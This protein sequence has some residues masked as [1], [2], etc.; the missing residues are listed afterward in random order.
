[1]S[2]R[3]LEIWQLAKQ[4]VTDIYKMTEMLP[5]SELYGITQQIRRSANS[6]L[7]NIVEGYGRRKY[8]ADYDKF[9]V[10]ALSSNHETTSHLEV[11]F[12]TGML[13]DK[14]LYHRLHKNSVRL[15]VKIN[16]FHQVLVRDIQ[17]QIRR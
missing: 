7:S 9:I 5:K 6:V 13:T 8:A 12:D 4:Q 3:N 16:N 17:S 14:E 11:I 15:G 2:Y 10:Y 1:M